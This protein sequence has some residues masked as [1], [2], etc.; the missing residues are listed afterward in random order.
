MSKLA[1]YNDVARFHGS[2]AEM[3]VIKDILSYPDKSRSFA[4]KKVTGKYKE[5][6]KYLSWEESGVLVFPSGHVDRV[7]RK[8]KP[9]IA[10]YRAKP[11]ESTHFRKYNSP[12][13][14]DYQ[15]EAVEACIKGE[16]GIIEASTGSGK[17]VIAAELI[18]RLEQ[19]TLFIVPTINILKQTY[20]RL[21]SMY[22]SSKVGMVG[23]G[24]CEMGKDIVIA[25][26]QSLLKIQPKHFEKFKVLIMDECLPSDAEIITEDG[27]KP[28]KWIVDNKY[29]GKVLSFNEKTNKKEWKKIIN[30]WCRPMGDEHWVNPTR[31]ITE[32]NTDTFKKLWCTP[33]HVCSYL[34]N[35]LYKEIKWC[36]A[37]DL[38]NRYLI[39]DP[40]NYHRNNIQPHY[41]SDQIQIILGSMLGD[42][43]MCKQTGRFKFSHGP[44]QEPYLDWKHFLLG[45]TGKKSPK[46]SG[47]LNKNSGF[48]VDMSTNDQTKYIRQIFKEKPQEFLDL[49]N[50]KALAIWYM[51][52]G[53]LTSKRIQLHT[54]GFNVDFIQ[55]LI[56]VLKTKFNVDAKMRQ[57]HKKT[58]KKTYNYIVINTENTRKF[59]KLVAPYRCYN[60][61][62]KF[63]TVTNIKRYKW[64]DKRELF[65]TI[66]IQNIFGSKNN[67]HRS[68]YKNKYDIEVEDNHNFYAN[69]YLVHNCQHCSAETIQEMIKTRTRSMYY[70]YYFSATPFRNDGS[71]IALEGVIGSKKL[72]VYGF[73]EGS[74]EGHVVEP[75]FIIFQYTHKDVD[76]KKSD[77]QQEYMNLIAE[78]E[79]Y[80][81]FI[82]QIVEDL[83]KKRRHIIVF[84]KF[85][86]QG[87]MLK[88]NIR[89]SVLITGLETPQD[90]Q[91]ILQDFGDKKFDVLIGTSVIGEGVDIPSADCGVMAGAGKAKSEVIQKIGRVLRPYKGKNDAWIVDVTHD[92]AAFNSRHAELRRKIYE[93]T[94]KGA[95]IFEV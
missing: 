95:K 28:I 33:G 51:D 18:Y 67:L 47:Y 86:S 3:A 80:N 39:I 66:K 46:W 62:Y 91:K 60:M 70:R 8:I 34:E 82:A 45:N 21:E 20:K 75:R 5:F 72:F 35:P 31:N 4:Y 89:G 15:E 38:K 79:D 11:K 53:S 50:E 14:R 2:P 74:K 76:F 81:K 43:S 52:D 32:T 27:V 36:R 77:F 13:L 25:T 30:W 23:G 16:R 73:D 88:K 22:K 85:I 19:P 63:K 29:S 83:R 56:D 40:T 71:D 58:N 92:N 49:V 55:K 10:D 87:E 61:N 42:G 93:A 1:L 24:K 59:L 94:Y 37:E 6:K 48:R 26:F 57:Y 69:G 78:N 17:T 9:E 84:V 54:E 64:N 44:K 65:G 7:I 68:T 90:S 41:N 12:T